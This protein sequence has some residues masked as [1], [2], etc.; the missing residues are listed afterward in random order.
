MLGG[1]TIGPF[2]NVELQVADRLKLY[3]FRKNRSIKDIF[4]TA[5][6]AYIDAD[7]EEAQLVDA[8]L[9]RRYG[10]TL[11]PPRTTKRE[12][13]DESPVPVSCEDQWDPGYRAEHGLPTLDAESPLQE[14]AQGP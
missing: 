5:V 6:M 9:M 14:P 10:G 8:D 4:I 2:L 3:A 1:N 7:V 13:R 12:L 11:P